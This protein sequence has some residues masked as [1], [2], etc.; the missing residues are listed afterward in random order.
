[1]ATTSPQITAYLP[2]EEGFKAKHPFKLL[3]TNLRGVYA[4]PAPPDSF[5]LKTASQSEL[6]KHGLPWRKPGPGDPPEL[7]KAWDRFTSRKWLAK[8]RIVPELH[9]QLGVTHNYRG[10]KPRQQADTSYLGRVW[11]G[12][13]TKTG[14]W[15]NA[16]LRLLE[17]SDSYCAAG[18]ARQ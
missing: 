2:D 1:M 12:A 5:D 6:I 18:T 11:A 4:V 3:S 16:Q 10:P 13:G 15:T 7:Q 9:P 8:D 14:K 17:D